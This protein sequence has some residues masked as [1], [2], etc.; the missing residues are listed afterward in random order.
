M[1]DCLFRQWKH[2][3][4]LFIGL[5]FQYHIISGNER[6]PTRNKT[7]RLFSNT[8]SGIDRLS[9]HSSHTMAIQSSQLIEQSQFKTKHNAQRT[10]IQTKLPYQGCG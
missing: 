8:V 10:E 9:Y 3:R 6:S 5:S 2:L 7:A 1:E 4:G